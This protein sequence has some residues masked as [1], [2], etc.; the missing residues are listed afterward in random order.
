[1]VEERQMSQ[2]KGHTENQEGVGGGGGNILCKG[3]IAYTVQARVFTKILQNIPE[4]N[5]R[6][7]FY[8][9]S[10]VETKRIFFI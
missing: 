8:N 5:F 7:F 10:V 4:G 6:K 2:L 9:N 1:M 3:K